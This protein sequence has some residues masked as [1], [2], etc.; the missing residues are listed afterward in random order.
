MGEKKNLA[1]VKSE[2]DRDRVNQNERQSE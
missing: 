1:A 2:R